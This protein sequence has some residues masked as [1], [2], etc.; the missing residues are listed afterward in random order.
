MSKWPDPLPFLWLSVCVYVPR[1]CITFSPSVRPLLG[2]M[3]RG[4]SKWHPQRRTVTAR[5][6]FHEEPESV[7]SV[8]AGS[9]EGCGGAG[10]RTGGAGRRVQRVRLTRWTRPAGVPCS[11]A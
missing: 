4:P 2:S 10:G 3:G 5:F 11:A 6:H 9:G 7:R 1:V 8:E